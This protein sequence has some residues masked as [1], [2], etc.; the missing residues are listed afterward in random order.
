MA[1]LQLWEH[2]DNMIFRSNKM[3][4]GGWSG[5]SGSVVL[6]RNTG[7]GFT[8]YADPSKVIQTNNSWQGT[9]R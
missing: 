5:G 7:E 1:T 6:D 3:A 4:S 8:V 2:G 9:T